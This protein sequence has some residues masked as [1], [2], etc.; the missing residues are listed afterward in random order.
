MLIIALDLYEVN[1]YK[2]YQKSLGI[3]GL[4]NAFCLQFVYPILLKKT[5]F[6]F[7]ISSRLLFVIALSS[8]IWYSTCYL[9]LNGSFLQTIFFSLG[10]LIFTLGSLYL[11]V[12]FVNLMRLMKDEVIHIFPVVISLAQVFSLA[13]SVLIIGDFLYYY[14][15]SGI[16][17]IVVYFMI[18]RLT[19]AQTKDTIDIRLDSVKC[20]FVNL[21]LFFFTPFSFHLI[22][23]DIDILL[24]NQFY[25]SERVF[26]SGSSLLVAPLMVYILRGKIELKQKRYIQKILAVL[27]ILTFVLLRYWVDEFY[28]IWLLWIPLVIVHVYNGLLSR[29]M[30]A[31]NLYQKKTLKLEIAGILLLAYTVYIFDVNFHIWFYGLSALHLL[32]IQGKHRLLNESSV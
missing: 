6:I 19:V 1:Q 12:E 28:V 5:D 11:Y 13:I 3:I 17:I 27:V 20:T 2:L 26:M 31:A 7:R 25:L 16:F 29:A 10:H 30:I 21:Y 23:D 15:F 22:F 14:W 4:I 24:R 32:Q 9:Y 8:F 18:S